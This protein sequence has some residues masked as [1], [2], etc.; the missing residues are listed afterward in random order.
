MILK[1]ADDI[2]QAVYWTAKRPRSSPGQAHA[3]ARLGAP[4]VF[5][6]IKSHIINGGICIPSPFGIFSIIR[7]FFSLPFSRCLLIVYVFP[8]APRQ[9]KIP[10]LVEQQLPCPVDAPVPDLIA[11]A[12]KM[13]Q[14]L[15]S[16]PSSLQAIAPARIK[17]PLLNERL[18]KKGETTMDLIMRAFANLSQSSGVRLRLNRFGEDETCAK[19]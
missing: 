2:Q 18:S 19:N 13:C 12:C 6:N 15:R 11:A 9:L 1:F 5:C 7:Y 8:T 14:G 4:S 10:L 16:E 3:C 17:P